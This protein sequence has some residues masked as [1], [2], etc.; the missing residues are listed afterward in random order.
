MNATQIISEAISILS[1]SSET[2]SSFNEDIKRLRSQGELSN[3]NR[4]RLGVIG[5]TSS[6]K[7]TLINALLGE[8]LLPAEAKPSSSQ[9]VSCH[10]G[11]RQATVFF[12]TGAKK[13]FNG[14]QLDRKLIDKYGNE[15]KNSKN[16]EG[17]E[18]IEL[19]T[20]HIPI[21]DSVIIVDS[22]GL[23]AYGFEGHEQIT[24][25]TLLPSVDFCLF[26]TTCKTNSDAKMLS[27]L[28][29]MS[30]YNKPV[31]IVQ[32]MIDSLRPSVDGKKSIQDVA[33][34]HIQR[35]QRI[36]DKSKISDKSLVHIVQIS[37]LRALSYRLV[38]FR[39]GKL[40]DRGKL[41]KKQ[42]N[43]EKFVEVLNSV[44]Q[45]LRPVIE[46]TRIRN[47]VNELSSINSIITQQVANKPIMLA[48]HGDLRS[49][50]ENINSI[51]ESQINSTFNS[52][53]SSIKRWGNK[54]SMYQRDIDEII[55]Q[56]KSWVDRI[57]SYIRKYNNDISDL[58][59]SLNISDRDIRYNFT[60]SQSTT[61]K[62]AKKTQVKEVKKSGF[63]NGVKRFFSFGT[64]GYETITEQIDDP[65]G[66][67]D[68]AIRYLESAA[69]N[70]ESQIR[71][72]GLSKEKT[73]ALL[74]SQISE[75]DRQYE[76]AQHRKLSLD[77][78]QEV[79][80]K[81][82][83]LIERAKSESAQ[84]TRTKPS[85]T[86]HGASIKY[87]VQ[88]IWASTYLT[89]SYSRVIISKLH[90]KAFEI[91]VG[92]IDSHAKNLNDRS[93]LVYSWDKYSL[94]R[95]IS[96]I[97]NINIDKV[98]LDSRGCAEIKNMKLVLNP[99]VFPYAQHYSVNNVIV[100]AN[101]TQP[102]A[103]A[104]QLSEASIDNLKSYQGNLI[105]VIQDLQET[106]N[107]GDFTNALRTM[108]NFIYSKLQQKPF[109][110]FPV[111]DNPLL[112]WAML[113][114]Q[115]KG[116]RNHSDELFIATEIKKKFGVLAD[117]NSMSMV[118]EIARAFNF[119]N[120]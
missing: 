44:F 38:E 73:E 106:L 88:S 80:K 109:T 6:G 23:D 30:R 34:D 82:T 19:Q 13:I 59:K 76:A 108:L 20:P 102:G 74:E 21:D 17:V 31:I 89:Y 48:Y 116:V 64:C 39:G 65:Q 62:I 72:W 87:S 75:K 33:N 103:S 56:H 37:A 77:K 24:M 91:A 119:N 22:P 9:L 58:C 47:I 105:F 7:S 55:K 70:L 101:F 112:V 69:Y 94:E 107:G 110:L 52:I 36:V 26:V 98:S 53:K 104:K 114:C 27:V 78:L 61:I 50:L 96:Q 83:K 25:E 12:K 42:S 120:V 79:G 16:K 14:N 84:Y 3:N 57:A 45:E 68:N 85:K 63:W 28:D 41:W 4:Y 5:V 71:R 10:K 66:T 97:S 86:T 18:Q 100:L 32:N 67:R 49:K 113:E 111:H 35:I 51:A 54:S 40:N 60:A 15:Q 1:S 11:P 118:H 43:F 93:S 8:E 95:F 90:K 29:T 81:L 99:K 46:A 92:D 115:A 2:Q 117:E